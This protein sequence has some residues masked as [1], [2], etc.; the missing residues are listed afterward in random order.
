MMSEVF[1]IT[2]ILAVISPLGLSYHVITNAGTSIFQN[3]D[4]LPLIAKRFIDKYQ[5]NAVP[6]SDYVTG[7]Y[8]NCSG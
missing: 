4:E 6:V 2:A 1:Y 8:I 7:I 3:Y 5:V